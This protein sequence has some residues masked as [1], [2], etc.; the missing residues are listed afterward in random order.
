[1][2][3]GFNIAQ[4]LAS[5]AATA[6]ERA[7]IIFPRSRRRPRAEVWSFQQLNALSDAYAHGLQCAGL[8][9]GMRSLVMIRPSVDGPTGTV[10]GA[11]VF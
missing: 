7:A 4:S 10:I 9:R 8:E 11:A 5:M 1:M 2:T 3:E 6:P